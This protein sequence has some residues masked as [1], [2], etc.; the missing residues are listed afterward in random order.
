MR[1]QSAA[2]DID[3]FRAET[4]VMYVLCGR[5]AVCSIPEGRESVERTQLLRREALELALYS[6][7][8]LDGIDNVLV[9]LPPRRG[10]QQ[11]NVVFLE[12]D[13]LAPA[14]DAPLGE[15]LTAPITP[16]IGEVSVD[17]ARSID[18][19]TRTRV[20][21]ASPLQQQDGSLIMVL[22]PALT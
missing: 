21:Q 20:F 12:R 18:R 4:N 19:Y 17:E 5:G 2:E 16:G 10:A 6:F 14:L 8:F 13:D 22:V 15:T 7:K 9:L 3:A 1:R 11:A